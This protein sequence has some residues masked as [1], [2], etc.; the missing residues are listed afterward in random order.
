MTVAPPR[1][2]PCTGVSDVPMPRRRSPGFACPRTGGEAESTSGATAPSRRRTVWIAAAPRRPS[3]RRSSSAARRPIGA[4]SSSAARADRSGPPP[5][6]I[7]ADRQRA[8][9]DAEPRE[10]SRGPRA[11]NLGRPAAPRRC[12]RRHSRGPDPR[13]PPAATPP[14]QPAPAPNSTPAPDTVGDTPAGRAPAPSLPLYPARTRVLLSDVD[15][16]SSHDRNRSPPVCFPPWRLRLVRA[17]PGPRLP[18]VRRAPTSRRAPRRGAWLTVTAAAELMGLPAA[19]VQRLLDDEADRRTLAVLR[20]DHVE[21]EPLRRLFRERQ[22]HNRRSPCRSW[23]A[24]S[25]ARRSRSSAG[26]GCD[27]RRRRPTGADDA[28]RP[29][30]S[31]RSASRPRA[32]SSARSATPRARS[33]DAD[34]A[35][36]HGRAGDQLPRWRPPP[37]GPCR[38]RRGRP[39]N[40]R[41]RAPRRR[42]RRHAHRLRRPSRTGVRRRH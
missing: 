37:R 21:N 32:G 42:R 17:S 24:A 8:D 19:S 20:R 40:P 11:L 13:S 39:A 41:H 26:S 25:A 2:S 30:R 5:V 22:R 10:R 38:A 31:P 1:E 27:R 12:G 29:G 3:S 9:A 6:R 18:G 36:Q 28:T 4:G 34:R 15:P 16:R 14:T 7:R 35:H 23:R 33:T